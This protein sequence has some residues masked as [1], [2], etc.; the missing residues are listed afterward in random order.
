MNVLY[1]MRWPYDFGARGG[2]L[3][4]MFCL[5]PRFD[6]ILKAVEPLGGRA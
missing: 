6:T 4:F 2:M 1:L 5:V 3:E